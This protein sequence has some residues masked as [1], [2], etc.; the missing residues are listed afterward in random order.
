MAQKIL[1][2][3]GVALGPKAACRCK[4]LMPDAEITLVDE[5]LFIS[6]GG[7]GIPYYVSGEVNNLDDLRATPYH[8]V[9][10]PEFFRTMKGITVRNQ[11]RAM[12]IDRAAKTLLVRNVVTGEE[13]KL[14]YDKLVLATGATPRMPPV[15]GHDLK[16]VLT[17]TRLE[18]AD[19]IRKACEHGPVHEAVIVGGGFIG[20]EAA[21]ALSDMWGVKVSVVE[22]M[23]Q[24]LPGVLSHNMG[25][26]AA[27]DCEA[28][29]LSVY[30]SEKVVKLEGKDGAVCKVI[31]DKRELPAQL[32]IFAAGFLPNGQLAK[33]A[34]LEVAPFGAIVVN[35]KMQT[36]DPDIYAGG[37][38]VAI[39]NLITGKLGYLPLGSMA[40]RQGRVIGTNL[41][42]GDASF[43]GFVGTWAVKLFDMSFCGAG[44]TVERARK[45]GYDAISVAVE[46]LDR[47]HFYPEKN[48]MSLELVV[49]KSDRRV[50]GIQGAC[51]AGDALKARIDA[52][53]AVLQYGKPTVED[54]SNLE[55]S[56]APPF[57]S[58][59]DVVNVV[60]NVADNVLAG[61]VKP[62]T[63]EEFMALWEKRAENNIF[64]IDARP[65]KAGQAVQAVH[66]EWHSIS[67]EEMPSRVNEVPKDRPVAIICNTG[68]RAYDSVLI[69]ARNGITDVVN[70][71][72][73]MQAVLKTGGKI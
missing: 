3:G 36:S 45:E 51:T 60:A 44:L 58:A 32:V 64:F 33:D 41:A 16:N 15:E 50:L 71:A 17:L 68:L 42:G 24:M 43:P 1:V 34:G 4:R 21:V 14:P 38:C 7:C 66:P 48:M 59:M 26:M 11:T 63:S 5:N 19:V 9:R 28:H 57:A 2:I 47:A 40:N 10:D 72:G 67:L 23:D 8:T 46:Q 31:T 30:T 37:D 20:L 49:D 53:A 35:E 65:A 52:V 39:K 61:R 25:K 70:A 55:I 62:I 56:Y 69:L 18:A 6:Y 12:A 29:G 73:G 27:H 13:E 22:M 54:I